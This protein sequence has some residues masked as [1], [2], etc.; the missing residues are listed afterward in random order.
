MLI[1]ARAAQGIMGALLSPA[2][3]AILLATYP[4]GPGRRKALGAW[5]ALMGL[6]AAT[7]L[8][9][10]GV[11][12]EIADWRWIFLVNLPVAA[13]ALLA[14]PRILPAFDAS[15]ARPGAERRRR[16]AGHAVAAAARVHRRRDREP[17]LDVR[18]LARSGS[19]SPRCSPRSSSPLSAAP[20]R[21]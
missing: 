1:A 16:H 6:G 8:L 10:G 19:P 13:A 20:P 4:E 2:A 15:T 11:L 9:A 21:R 17:G 5:A 14:I 3:L 7:G 12:V 18:A